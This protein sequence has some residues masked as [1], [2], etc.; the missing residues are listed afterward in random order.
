MAVDMTRV[1]LDAVADAY[2]RDGYALVR[3]A[4]SAEEMAP[5]H[6]QWQRVRD[7]LR[8]RPRQSTGSTRQLLYPR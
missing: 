2:E 3:N 6:E 8:G 4:L 7:P 1:D 5:I